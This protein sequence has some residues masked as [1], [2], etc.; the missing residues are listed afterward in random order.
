[1]A[2]LLS[3]SLDCGVE[4]RY[5]RIV[6]YSVDLSPVGVNPGVTGPIATVHI[7]EYLDDKS[8]TSGARPVR[9]ETATFILEVGDL[10]GDLRPV[11]YSALAAARYSGSEP[12]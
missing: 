10:D 2:L 4:A 5:H 7:G 6:A 12:A 11:L 9:V 1:M 3:K 8:R